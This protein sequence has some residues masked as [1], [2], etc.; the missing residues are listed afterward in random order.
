[1]AEYVWIDAAGETR[2][3]SRVSSHRP[4]FVPS[5]TQKKRRHSSLLDPRISPWLRAAVAVALAVALAIRPGPSKA[6][7]SQ[8]THDNGSHSPCNQE[9]QVLRGPGRASC[10]VADS[11]TGCGLCRDFVI[12][13]SLR[14]IHPLGVCL[15]CRR[16]VRELALRTVLL[17][18]PWATA[19]TDNAPLP[20]LRG[21][22]TN[23]GVPIG[24]PSAWPLS[25]PPLLLLR[26]LTER[27]RQGR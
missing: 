23:E 15:R 8:A 2:S 25:T 17:G 18:L 19:A 26:A 20:P 1:M 11:H 22:A 13:Q 27:F 21:R 10:L 24:C 12:V 16:T 3:K 6:V 5:R 9:H 14:D 7:R 4:S